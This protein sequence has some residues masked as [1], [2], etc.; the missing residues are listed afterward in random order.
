MGIWEGFRAGEGLRVGEEIG[1]EVGKSGRIKGDK[2]G[3]GY[4]LGKGEWA[5]GG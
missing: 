3:K 2:R 5:M 1:L 4:G